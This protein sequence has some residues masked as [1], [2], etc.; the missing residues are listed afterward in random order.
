M[1]LCACNWGS[2]HPYDNEAMCS[3]QICSPLHNV[4]C[5]I[6]RRLAL[7]S[8]CRRGSHPEHFI[9]LPGACARLVLPVQL[10]GSHLGTR[11][12]EHSRL[13]LLLHERIAADNGG[14]L[15]AVGPRAS[16]QVG[17]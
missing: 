7:R 5:K 15:S 4:K 9:S 16:E 12:S 10:G 11:S 17:G 14:A 6:P 1:L 8:V 3:C 13:V 2:R